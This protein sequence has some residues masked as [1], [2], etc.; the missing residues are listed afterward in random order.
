MST[1]ISLP[2]DTPETA[3]APAGGQNHNI[4]I[5]DADANQL[6]E[7]YRVVGKKRYKVRHTFGPIDDNV[8]IEY[9]NRARLVMERDSNGE[10]D[11]T[12]DNDSIA[13]AVYL[14]DATA[15]HIDG[16]NLDGVR[17]WKATVISV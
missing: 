3:A 14:H 5:Y 15:R 1:Q 17:D 12:L 6:I 10:S 7:S 9:F 4:N 2:V 13:A 16:V 8:Q 11:I